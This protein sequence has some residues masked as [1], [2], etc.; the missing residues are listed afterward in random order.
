[1]AKDPVDQLRGMWDGDAKPILWLGAGA[2]CQADPP[3]STLWGLVEALKAKH[4]RTWDPPALDDPYALIDNFVGELGEG[5][6]H[7]F[8]ERAFRPGGRSPEPGPLHRHLA[9][10]VAAGRF[11]LIIDTTY[12][13]LL[14]R[15]CDDAGAAYRFSQLDRGLHLPQ[16]GLPRFLA[17]HGTWDDWTSVV[18][19]GQSFAEYDSRHPLAIHELELKLRQHRV[20]FV[21]CSLQDPRLLNWMT[22]LGDVE[23]RRLH[24]WR[25]L[26]A[27]GEGKKLEGLMWK[28]RSY[29]KV[30]ASIKQTELPDFA[31]LPR[32][33]EQLTAEAE[34]P[35][36]RQLDVLIRPGTRWTIEAA[37]ERVEVDPPAITPAELAKLR[38]I[39]CDGFPCE[40]DGTVVTAVAT[41]LHA[42]EALARGVGERL[43]ALLPGK[44]NERLA[45]LIGSAATNDPAT[46]HLRVDGEPTAVDAV[47]LLP[48]ELLTVGGS[49]A[50]ESGQLH[51]VREVVV[52]GAQ[53]L[54]N[55]VTS[56]RILAHVAAPEG[57]DMVELDLE[58]AAY[59]IARALDPLREHT[60]F[61]E[62]GTLD[63]LQEAARALGHTTILH[64]SG[65]GSP[66]GLWFENANG[67]P[68]KVSVATLCDGLAAVNSRLPA[69]VWLSCCYGAGTG[70]RGVSRVREWGGTETAATEPS[71]AAALHRRGIPQVLGYFGPVADALAARVDRDLFSALV[72]TGR[73]VEAV[74][75]A[76][77][78]SKRVLDEGGRWAI[79]PLAWSMLALYHRGPDQKLLDPTLLKHPS[80][81]SRDVLEPQ[82]IAI[83]GAEGIAVLEHGFIGRRRVLA[84]LRK[85]VNL[86]TRALGL[87]G[88]GGLG[89][90]ATMTRLAVVLVGARQ[91]AKDV[92]VLPFGAG[93]SEGGLSSR[94]F[95]G[96]HTLVRDIVARHGRCPADWAARMQQ[97]DELRDSDAQ[98]EALARALLVAA[99]E[100]VLYLDNLETLQVHADGDDPAAWREPAIE[101]FF[102]ALTREVPRSTTILM[103]SR[104]RPLGSCGEWSSLL[105]AGKGEIFRMSAWWDP[106]RRLPF[107]LREAL[108]ENID[109]HPLTVVWINSLL[110]EG[111]TEVIAPDA[112]PALV[113]KTVLDPALQSLGSRYKQELVLGELIRRL[114]AG[115]RAVLGECAEARKPVTRELLDRL[116]AGGKRLIELGL[117]TRFGDDHW[118]LHSLV[119]Q[120][121]KDAGIPWTAVGRGTLG[122]F[123]EAHAPEDADLDGLREA[124]DH[125]L[126]AR[127][128]EDAGRVMTR[129]CSAMTRAGLHHASF[130]FLEE[131]D[132]IEWPDAQRNA[133]LYLSSGVSLALGFFAKAE[134]TARRSVELATHIHGTRDHTDVAASL[135]GL[136]NVLVSLGKF[137][138]AE[139]S[140]ISVVEIEERVFG[141]R[142][143]ATTIPTL[144][145][146]ARLLLNTK[147]PVDALEWSREAWTAAIAGKLWLEVLSAGPVLIA[148]LAATRG[149]GIEEVRSTLLAVLERFPEQ[150]PARRRALAE[151]E[152]V[153]RRP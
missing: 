93:R 135:H 136:A 36:A 51:L 117:I 70:K 21:G 64:F 23:R 35:N 33:F 22:G 118:G 79:F 112:D 142:H 60:R 8:F 2:S 108:V 133:W 24:L 101:R 42:A 119:R 48:W 66:G 84:E 81:L 9:K 130:A 63:D 109:G 49:F 39:A 134:E 97:I 128:F 13:L 44:A 38:G 92:I 116:G 111:P 73:T 43:A 15:A 72:E 149:T 34:V 55:D 30:L 5:E 87:Y 45:A 82:K 1:M 143:T 125:Y 69:A 131:L 3:L 144:L 4:A 31:S 75:R 113:R 65:H 77:V 90:T 10:L 67:G 126:A 107:V 85:R 104:C 114:P 20:L 139:T 151:L 41:K 40:A 17:L 58:A 141:S 88:L 103:T 115:E 137:D 14:R 132:S 89:K 52:A 94:L 53:H 147:R 95:A 86:G 91:T 78:S 145:S 127:R 129:V 148:C 46:L 96:L 74:R 47:M 12:D 57:E 121:V 54:P 140:W 27:P 25:A 62:L 120:A 80:R 99:H 37:G 122:E 153:V 76:R 98:A 32:W 61:T 26:L 28:G 124:L 150:H 100:G 56:P 68:E 18:L 16:E 110:K 11:E 105:V 123:R 106:M 7:R 146:L 71:I 138:E 59:R 83:E 102:A 6:L 152:K 50:L 19:T 29:A